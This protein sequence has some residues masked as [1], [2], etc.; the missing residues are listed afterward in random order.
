[1]RYLKLYEQFRLLRE[2]KREFAIAVEKGWKFK[3]TAP[4]Q[5]FEIKEFQRTFESPKGATNP[6]WETV[7]E[8]NSNRPFAKFDVI[9][10]SH[11][12]L[13]KMEMSEKFGDLISRHTDPKIQLSEEQKKLDGL[14][15]NKTSP[16]TTDELRNSLKDLLKENQSLLEA[17][18]DFIDFC[19]EVIRGGKI[20]QLTEERWR[21][22]RRCGKG[23]EAY[24]G[25]KPDLVESVDL[26]DNPDERVLNTLEEYMKKKQQDV[27]WTYLTTAL[28]LTDESE[29]TKLNEL[30]KKGYEVM[31]FNVDN[32]KIALKE[33]S[34]SKT[35][36]IDLSE[37]KQGRYK[38][39][40]GYIL[41]K[42]NSKYWEGFY[43]EDKSDQLFSEYLRKTSDFIQGDG[44][45][46]L[47][48]PSIWNIGDYEIVIGGN[49]R[50]VTFACLGALPK[51]WVCKSL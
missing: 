41:I 48:P 47:C 34:D 7:K 14:D 25:G 30:T 29:R 35:K 32:I 31:S 10:N 38:G 8:K 44:K 23:T 28:G 6:V 49:R 39:T 2:N 15:A 19:E 50:L 5:E 40:R 1:M 27:N 33:G 20:E 51:V 4:E 11:T 24:S 3:E 16:I 22:L 21:K 26:L 37:V 43:K 42:T 17:W 36:E 46:N 45:T 12:L 9:N 18:L 13:E